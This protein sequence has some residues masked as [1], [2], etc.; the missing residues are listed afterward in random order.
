MFISYFTSFKFEED[1]IEYA[2]IY[3]YCFPFPWLCGIPVYIRCRFPEVSTFLWPFYI[4][5]YKFPVIFQL[6]FQFF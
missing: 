3:K 5:V 2:V 6:S 4:F 1:F